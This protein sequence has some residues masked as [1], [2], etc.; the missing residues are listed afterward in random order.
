MDAWADGRF[1]TVVVLVAHV[2]LLCG[3]FLCWLRIAWMVW[4]R[5]PIGRR[6]MLADGVDSYHVI[7]ALHE[8]AR[9]ETVKKIKRFLDSNVSADVEDDHG[10]TALMWASAIGRKDVVAELLN[11]GADTEVSKLSAI[12]FA[13]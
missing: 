12:L 6:N 11:N 1:V 7:L 9:N 8:A 10:W 5:W 2:V 13:K 3:V 4:T